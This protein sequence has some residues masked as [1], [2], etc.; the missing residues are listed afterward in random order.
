MIEEITK[1]WFLVR[2]WGFG[3]SLTISTLK[4][5]FFGQKELFKGL[6][7][8]DKLDGEK[9][10][11]WPVIHLDMSEIDASRGSQAF[12]DSLALYTLKLAENLKI[13]IPPTSSASDLFSALISRLHQK[14]GQQVAVLID[15]YD[16]PIVSLLAKPTEVKE[17]R[18]TLCEYYR[19]LKVNDQHISFAFMT[20]VTKY[21]QKGL[22]SACDNFRDISLND[23]F[24]TM[25]GFTLEELKSYYGQRVKEIA[26]SRRETEDNLLESLTRFYDGYSFDGKG[27][28][29]NPF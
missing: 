28:V 29:F 18:E 24:G 22:Y 8:Y 2:P 27:L 13:K 15:E 3:K 5:L 7:I 17:T 26:K 9:F 12:Y 20:G 10:A 6:A 4:S 1:S 19:Q 14:S 25:M 11:P 21:V 16:A 23:E